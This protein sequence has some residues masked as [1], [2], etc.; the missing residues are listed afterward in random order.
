[1]ILAKYA[2]EVRAHLGLWEMI[3]VS[4]RSN[5]RRARD[6]D[7]RYDRQCDYR[8]GMR[9]VRAILPLRSLRPVGPS[10]LSYFVRGFDIARCLAGAD[11]KTRGGDG[12][13]RWTDISDSLGIFGRVKIVLFCFLIEEA[14]FSQEDIFCRDVSVLK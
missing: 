3:G 11:P 8:R 2:G 12:I 10:F 4:A 9:I 13:V 6:S 14:L 1:M 7:K 5:L